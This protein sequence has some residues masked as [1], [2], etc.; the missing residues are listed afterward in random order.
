MGS[1]GCE[2]SVRHLAV[3]VSCRRVCRLL[4]GSRY[5]LPVR[6]AF[7]GERCLGYGHERPV[8]PRGAASYHQELAN[9]ILPY[10]AVRSSSS[11]DEMVLEFFQS[12]Y[13]A[14]A[15]RAGWNRAALDRAGS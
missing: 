15:D 1:A 4:C 10:E 9:F 2:T 6:P 3:T 11:P 5:P 12:A 7:V 8:G 13:D 14:A